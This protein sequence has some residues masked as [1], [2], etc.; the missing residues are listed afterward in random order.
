MGTRSGIHNFNHYLFGSAILLLGIPFLLMM[1]GW[2]LSENWIGGWLVVAYYGPLFVAMA[3]L[4][5]AAA[6]HVVAKN[7]SEV[8]SKGS[9]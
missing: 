8:V 2:A 1:L 3:L 5:L 9:R 4:L 7:R 6:L